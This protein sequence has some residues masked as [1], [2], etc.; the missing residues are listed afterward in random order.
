MSF[1]VVAGPRDSCRIRSGNQ[2]LCSVISTQEHLEISDNMP[3][4]SNAVG[5]YPVESHLHVHWN[6]C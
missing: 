4:Y 5:E 2:D 1:V 3:A 6:W